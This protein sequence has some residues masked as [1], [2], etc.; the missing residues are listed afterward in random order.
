MENMNPKTKII[1]V[2]GKN[3]QIIHVEV[4]QLGGEYDVASSEYKF[5]D[6]IDQIEWVSAEMQNVIKSVSPDKATIEF[7]VELGLKSNKLMALLVD[8]SAKGNFKVA[9]E[10]NSSK[11]NS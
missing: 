2:E 1:E 5:S 7:G 8:A 10:W 3:G 9:L 11:N 6:I 4:R